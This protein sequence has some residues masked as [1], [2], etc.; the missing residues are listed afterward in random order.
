MKLTARFFL[1]ILI[2][3]SCAT[4]KEGALRDLPPDKEY[5]IT[6]QRV[7]DRRLPS[8]TE[9]EFQDMLDR[10]QGYIREYLGYRVSFFVK[11]NKDLLQVKNE[12]AYIRNLDSMKEL[13]TL[14]LDDNSAGDTQR[15]REYLARLIG[16][17]D[18]SMLQSYV[19]GYSAFKSRDALVDF[20]YR[21]YLKKL[22]LINGIRTNDGTPLRSTPYADTLTYPFWD[23]LL[24]EIRGVN[25]I[26]TNTV[27]ADLELDIPIYVVLRYGITTG[28]VEA[29]TSNEYGGAGVI[30][31]YPF[32]AQ[33][34]FFMSEREEQIPPDK[35]TDVIA[36]YAAHEFGHLL[37]HYKDFYS[38][39]NCIMV[40]AN[41]LNYYRWYR[42]RKEKKCAL[43]HEKLKH[44]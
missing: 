2:T 43:P 4:L 8:L 38:H 13:K 41:D 28:M 5:I 39:K 44:F 16:A 23:M 1:I 27:M 29:N 36:L 40:P 30:F 37:N 31:T 26:F 19:P 9:S 12:F 14:L 15:F 22:K 25:F 42:E 24:R 6:V 10:L 32:T 7:L 3:A 33:D 35:L 18:E 21:E 17:A 34:G 20:L 11:G